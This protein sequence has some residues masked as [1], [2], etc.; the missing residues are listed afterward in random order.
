MTPQ[1]PGKFVWFEHVCPDIAKARS[2][3][4]PLLGWHVEATPMGAQTHHLIY[5]G[6]ECIGGFRAAEA[7]TPSHWASYLS[8]ADVDR[9]H[10]AACKAG[11][12]SLMAPTD[13]KPV[14]RGATITDPTG[15]A[16]CL[17]NGT[18]G[19]RIDAEHTAIGDW[20]WNELWTSD[21]KKALAFY[22]KV[23]GYT[24]DAMDLGPQGTYYLLKGPDGKMRGGLMQNTEAKWS[25]MW[26]P[27]VQVA[28]CDASAA[29]ATELGARKVAV[30]PTDIP[31]VGRFAVLIDPF[32]AAVAI[33]RGA[34]GD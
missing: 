12:K 24:H 9:S 17:W 28:D 30:P 34:F 23:F 18:D 25:P 10:A 27:Y 32:G 29:R 7:D 21:A 5:S 31:D 8:V 3:Y 4:E 33:I 16:L 19:D 11:A 26:L 15:A 20:F 14:G 1:L 2:F 13:F 6:H 22:E